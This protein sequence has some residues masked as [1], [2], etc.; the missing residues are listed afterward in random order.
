VELISVFVLLAAGASLAWIWSL[1]DRR[2]GASKALEMLGEAGVGEALERED[3]P[4]ALAMEFVGPDA[5]GRFGPA[6]DAE[7]IASRHLVGVRGLFGEGAFHALFSMS[8][9]STELVSSV[10]LVV[11]VPASSVSALEVDVWS[12]PSSAGVHYPEHLEEWLDPRLRA[13]GPEDDLL[14]LLHGPFGD[15]LAQ[16]RDAVSRIRFDP[17]HMDIPGVDTLRVYTAVRLRGGKLAVVGTLSRP[18]P[19]EVVSPVIQGWLE[20][21]SACLEHVPRGARRDDALAAIARDDAAVD[22]ARWRA[23]Y[24]LGVQMGAVDH[25]SDLAAGWAELPAPVQ[26]ALACH[27]RVELDP[28]QRVGLLDDAIARGGDLGERAGKALLEHDA[29]LGFVHDDVD[30]DLR[31]EHALRALSS[32]STPEDHATRDEALAR[33]FASGLLGA[34]GSSSAFN[35]MVDAGWSPAPG[36]LAVIARGAYTRLANDIIDLIAARG[37]TVEDAPALTALRD[38][39]HGERVDPMLTALREGLDAKMVGRLSVSEGAGAQ[40]GLTQASGGGEL[41]V[42]GEE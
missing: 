5:R 31:A 4:R 22:D 33:V 24:A 28:E 19:R 12:T 7:G 32:P 34:R 35:A 42:V 16:A 20:D 29:W 10:M 25:L 17:A 14:V 15:A 37:T 8:E 18:T 40:G 2:G 39:G 23:T 27:P 6:I 3:A 13:D 26:M 21:V 38:R 11:D 9:G 36:A 1:A 41:E 30:A